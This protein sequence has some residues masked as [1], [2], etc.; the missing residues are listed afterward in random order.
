MGTKPANKTNERARVVAN[1]ANALK[2]NR[3][4]KDVLPRYLSMSTWK[5]KAHG[6]H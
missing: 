6:G 4:R 1:A 5:K 3:K 2:D